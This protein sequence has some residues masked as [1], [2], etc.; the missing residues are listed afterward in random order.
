MVFFRVGLAVE[1]QLRLAEMIQKTFAPRAHLARINALGIGGEA[2]LR[3]FGLQRVVIA[4]RIGAIAH[5]STV[6]RLPHI[7]VP[8]VV[9]HGHDRPVDWYFLEIGA[10][11]ADKLRIG[12]GKQPALQQRVV[13]EIDARYHMAYMECRLLRFSEEVFRIAV[14]G[15]FTYLD[16][17]YQ[18]LR[19]DFSRVEQ[20]ELVFKFILLW[21]DLQAQLIFGEITAFDRI[22]KVATMEIGVF[23]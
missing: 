17:R 20:V 4:Q 23:A 22:P 15:H 13:R 19:D 8:L 18:L 16:N 3:H 14:E 21:Y 7:A 12:V 11:Q 10:A 9:V 1:E 2:A 5:F 6:D